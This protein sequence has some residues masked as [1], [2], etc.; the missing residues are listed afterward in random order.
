MIPCVTPGAGFEEHS[1]CRNNYECCI[2]NYKTQF[3]SE[4]RQM[5]INVSR[6]GT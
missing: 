4:L 1:V 5:L 2:N 3:A 6:I